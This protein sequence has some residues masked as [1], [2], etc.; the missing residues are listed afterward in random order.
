M[1]SLMVVFYKESCM[2]L[3]TFL[4]AISIVLL[5]ILICLEAVFLPIP[6]EF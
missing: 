4:S 6:E 3:Y 1:R 5:G 2:S